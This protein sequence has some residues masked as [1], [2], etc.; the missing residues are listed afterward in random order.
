MFRR[1]VGITQVST[2][3]EIFSNTAFFAMQMIAC[4]E[5]FQRIGCLGNL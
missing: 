5:D 2:P 1:T 4:H 3:T